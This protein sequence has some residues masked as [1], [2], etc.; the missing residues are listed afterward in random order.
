MNFDSELELDDDELFLNELDRSITELKQ[1]NNVPSCG[2]INTNQTSVTKDVVTTQTDTTNQS[3]YTNVPNVVNSDQVK[4]DIKQTNTKSDSVTQKQISH[5][6]DISILQDDFVNALSTVS[7]LQSSL[8]AQ[9][10]HSFIK[11][12]E[13]SISPVV[14]ILEKLLSSKRQMNESINKKPQML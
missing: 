8:L 4:V 1:I 6:E 13:K 5:S 10:E 11:S 3:Q 14:A 2:N 9:R 7:A 12:I